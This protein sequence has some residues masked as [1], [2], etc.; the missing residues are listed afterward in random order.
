[1]E[2]AVSIN[3]GERGEGGVGARSR[4]TSVVVANYR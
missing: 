2:K 1:M 3:C 4:P